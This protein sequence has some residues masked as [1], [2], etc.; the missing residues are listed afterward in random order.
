MWNLDKICNEKQTRATESHQ[1]LKFMQNHQRKEKKK[2]SD[3]KQLRPGI[4]A[5]ACTEH[6]Q[7]NKREIKGLP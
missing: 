1:G 6:T 5:W 4:C 2:S 7:K 3:Q